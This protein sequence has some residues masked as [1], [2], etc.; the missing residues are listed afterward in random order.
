MGAMALSGMPY[1]ARG[2]LLQQRLL[3][4]VPDAGA[5]NASGV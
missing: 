4:H 3:A 5:V 2:A 1:R